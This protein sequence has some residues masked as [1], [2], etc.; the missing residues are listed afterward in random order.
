MARSKLDTSR[1]EKK[2]K[3]AG[4]L[5]KDVYKNIESEGRKQFKGKSKKRGITSSKK[6]KKKK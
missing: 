1:I 3:E 5:W 4:A 6:I 2:A